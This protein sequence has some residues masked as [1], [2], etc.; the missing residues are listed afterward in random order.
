M[1]SKMQ[2]GV[3]KGSD[4][5]KLAE[6]GIGDDE[7]IR[8]ALFEATPFD[9]WGIVRDVDTEFN[10]NFGVM[11]THDGKRLAFNIAGKAIIL[12]EEQTRLFTITFGQ[13]D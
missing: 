13:K 5:R 4:G 7:S 10:F 9:E 11:W 2:V 12:D 1:V 6:I 8:L 3:V